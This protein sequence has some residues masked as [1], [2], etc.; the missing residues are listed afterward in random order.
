MTEKPHFVR[1]LKED[2]KRYGGNYY[3]CNKGT[4]REIRCRKPNLYYTTIQG[5]SQSFATVKDA[6]ETNYLCN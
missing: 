2:H 3:V 1:L 4:V 5:I 6:I